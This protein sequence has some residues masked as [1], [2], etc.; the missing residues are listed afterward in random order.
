MLE[1]VAGW[2][3]R[4]AIGYHL[5]EFSAIRRTTKP[6]RFVPL[7]E[8][9][10]RFDGLYTRPHDIRDGKLWCPISQAPMATEFANSRFLTPWLVTG[11]WALF[12]DFSDMLFLADPAEL[13][14]LADPKY[15]VMVVKREH[16]PDATVKMDGQAQTKYARKNWSS[17]IL[18]NVKHRAHRKLTRRMVNEL[19]GRELHRF[20]WLKDKEIGEL[21]IEWN[22]LAGTDPVD[23]SATGRKPKLLHYTEG[24]PTMAGYENGPWADVWNQELAILD[25][26]RGGIRYAA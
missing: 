3:A 4:E 10:L 20:C 24:L 7:R 19:P 13:F 22:W 6:L 21:P 12:C 18:W 15:A 16:E 2:D 14:A 1:I 23:E 26:T 17:V 5:C 25:A 11:H 8:K 9:A